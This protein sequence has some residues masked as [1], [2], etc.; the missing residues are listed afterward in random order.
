M[1]EPLACVVDASVAIKLFLRSMPWPHA[2][3]ARA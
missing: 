1:S 3:R 2:S